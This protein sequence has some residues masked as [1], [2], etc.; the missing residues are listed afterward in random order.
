MRQDMRGQLPLGPRQAR[1]E[2]LGVEI[3]VVD[4]MPLGL[5]TLD[6]QTVH[7]GVEAGLYRVGIENEDFHDALC[8]P[9]NRKVFS[10]R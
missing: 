5:Q 9:R 1:I 2:I 3:A 6:D 10:D 7:R 4:L 8:S